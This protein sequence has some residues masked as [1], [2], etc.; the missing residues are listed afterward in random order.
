MSLPKRQTITK[1][2][3]RPYYVIVLVVSTALF[4]GV[5]WLAEKTAPQTGPLPPPSPPAA[6]PPISTEL[7]LVGDVLREQL[8]RRPRHEVSRKGPEPFFTDFAADYL[9]GIITNAS[10]TYQDKTIVSFAGIPIF[11]ETPNSPSIML[12]RSVHKLNET[13]HWKMDGRGGN[14]SIALHEPTIIHSFGYRHVNVTDVHPAP[15]HFTFAV[16]SNRHESPHRVGRWVYNATVGGLQRFYLEKPITAQFVDV[17]VLSNHGDPDY[18]S[19]FRFFVFG[20]RDS[21]SF[22]ELY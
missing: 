4:C 5:S 7:V 22:M 18:T 1:V 16:R 2:L 11:Y 3:F 10:P 20:E 14:F 9:G 17:R 13:D 19:M 6:Q 12:H 15:A 8:R 21:R